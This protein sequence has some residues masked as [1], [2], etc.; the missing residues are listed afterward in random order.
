[1]LRLHFIHILFVLFGY[2]LFNM[3]QLDYVGEVLR[4]DRIV[5]TP[6]NVSAS[7]TLIICSKLK[8]TILR[9]SFHK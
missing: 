6:Y 8:V 4:G 9:G 7:V 1:M 5:N 2:L 3:M